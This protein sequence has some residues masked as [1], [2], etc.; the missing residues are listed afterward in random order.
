MWLIAQEDF[1][2]IF[3]LTPPV[4]HC[5]IVY[6]K[7]FSLIYENKFCLS[8]LL[9]LPFLL[10]LFSLFQTLNCLS[11]IHNI[12]LYPA[13]PCVKIITSFS[14][15]CTVSPC[16]SYWLSRIIQQFDIAC[17]CLRVQKV[18]QVIPFPEPQVHLACLVYLV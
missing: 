18:H 8:V 5:M 3:L 9:Q 14:V 4:F 1:I 10:T 16:T 17:L 11:A 7:M 13:F 12:L 2:N 6:H 15:P